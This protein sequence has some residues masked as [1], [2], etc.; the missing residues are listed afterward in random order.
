MIKLPS[1]VAR[2]VTIVT[3]TLNQLPGL[4][5][6]RRKFVAALIGTMLALRG[7]VNYRNL[8]RYGAYC[9]H[10]YA[11]QFAQPFPW[12]AYH[13]QVLQ[14]AVPASHQ[15]IAA[16]DASFIP[17]SGKRTPGLDRFYNGCAGRA[18]RGLEI[19]A[20]AVID[21]TQKGAYVAAVAQ[22]PA[23]PTLKKA[24]AA[25]TRLDHAVQ[26]VQAARPYWPADLVYLA[27][28]GADAKKKYVDAVVA[29]GL[30]VVTKL[31]HDANMRFRYTGERTGQRGR[32]KTYDGKVNWRDLCRFEARARSALDLAPDVEAYTQELYHC[33]LK[34]WLRVVVLVWYTSDGKR[35]HAIFATTDLACAPAAVL[36]LYQGRFQLEFLFRDG[37]QFA[38]LSE[39]QARDEAA[40][41]FHF[42]A[43]LATVSAT[44]AALAQEQPNEEPFVFSL[45][46]QKQ[47]AFNERFLAAISAKYGYDLNDWKN[48]PSYE[49]LRTYGALAA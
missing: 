15:R 10:S 4:A 5:K 37:K 45:A 47:L 22:T 11:R 24:D 9:E 8:A 43:A 27:A 6:P 13:A 17:K 14:Q 40:L 42:N 1:L 20:L 36:R 30:Q 39:S 28:D 33:S 2:P 18:E 48:H 7:R 29:L 25:A 26:Q 38:G 32:P 19:S 46:T 35:H 12:L 21:L 23:T 34:R 16:Q 41:D 44:R 49:E 3:A 31:R